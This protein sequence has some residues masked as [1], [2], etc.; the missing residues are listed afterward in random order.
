MSTS[1]ARFAIEPDPIFARQ[2]I[3]MKIAVVAHLKYPIAEPFAGGLEA[4]TFA[5]VAGLERA[6]H[7]VALF[8]AA[9]S[10]ATDLRSVCAPTGA[11]APEVAD[12]HEALAYRAVLDALCTEA[13]DIVHFNALHFLPIDDAAR[14]PAPM[15]AVLH[16]PPFP[17]LARAMNAAPRNVTLVSVSPSLSA[18]WPDLPREPIVV[19]NGVDLERFRFAAHRAAPDFALWCGR[20][21]PEKGLHLAIDAARAAGVALRICGPI[22]D[23]DYWTTEIAGRLGSDAVYLG[24][25]SHDMVAALLGR[26]SVLVCTPCWEEPFG[27]VVVEALACGTP[28]A[29][30]A[31]GA[32]V[33]ILDAT[34][35]ALAAP[36]DVA[37]LA[38]AIVTALSLDRHACRARAELFGTD[39]MIDR[40]VA[41]YRTLVV[42]AEEASRCD[43]LLDELDAG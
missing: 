9:G 35:G 2:S 39:L 5:L 29:G 19:D 15:V 26:A 10:A 36:G 21:V 22:V 11:L 16:C 30:F 12:R 43:T 28:V 18:Q 42:A 27:L 6:G 38:L 17:P 25:V 8:A 3:A 4:H 14:L 37:A 33:D 20:I 24:H 1:V 32:L 40:Y 7:D 13:F 34:C 31:R 23:R 41:L